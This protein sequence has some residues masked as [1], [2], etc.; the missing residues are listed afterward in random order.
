MV[1]IVVG[2]GTDRVEFL[3]GVHAS[4]S[5]HGPLSSSERLVGVLGS[6]VQPAAWL[7]E[8]AVADLL[9]RGA[10]GA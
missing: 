2:R 3:E 4:I 10:V 8:A 7:L 5:Q 9:H 6:V 1:E